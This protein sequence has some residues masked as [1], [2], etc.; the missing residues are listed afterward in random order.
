LL[1]EQCCALQLFHGRYQCVASG[2]QPQALKQPVKQS[3]PAESRLEPGQSA[4]NRRLAQPQRATGGAQRSM[5][6]DAE[7]HTNVVPI[8]RPVAMIRICIVAYQICRSLISLRITKLSDRDL[9]TEM[10]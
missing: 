4:A 3:P 5:T 7:K 9:R 8:H 6:G 1:E 2:I 10:P